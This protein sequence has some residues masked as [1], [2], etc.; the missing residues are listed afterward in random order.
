[1]FCYHRYFYFL[2]IFLKSSLLNLIIFFIGHDY[3]IF[4]NCGLQRKCGFPVCTVIWTEERKYYHSDLCLYVIQLQFSFL[5]SGFKTNNVYQQGLT[6]WTPLVNGKCSYSV[7]TSQISSPRDHCSLNYLGD[8]I[9]NHTENLES[10]ASGA[11]LKVWTLRVCWMKQAHR[12]FQ[13]LELKAVTIVMHFLGYERGQF[14]CRHSFFWTRHQVLPSPE[15]HLWL[16]EVPK[17]QILLN[18]LTF[19]YFFNH[20]SLHL[21]STWLPL[22][23]NS[24]IIIS[25]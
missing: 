22:S 3:N 25:K 19:A 23:E 20:Q 24:F 11:F 8:S 1:M 2:L 12:I 5:H 6:S 14:S 16:P 9:L 21:W 18:Q 4:F 7:S 17:K 15:F 13:L 10:F